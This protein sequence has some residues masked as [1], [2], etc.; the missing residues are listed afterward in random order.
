MTGPSA[1]DPLDD[2][3]ARGQIA[4]YIPLPS[5]T[6]NDKLALVGVR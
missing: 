4:K 5:D 6:R 2:A 1:T 3:K